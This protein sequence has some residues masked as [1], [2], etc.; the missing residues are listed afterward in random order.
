M[1]KRRT[2]FR[3][4]KRFFRLKN[5]QTQEIKHHFVVQSQKT[6]LFGDI[7]L[8]GKWKDYMIK[9]RGLP[10]EK[11]IKRPL[12]IGRASELEKCLSNLEKKIPKDRECY[13][14]NNFIRYD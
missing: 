1:V 11:T 4:V 7:K 14:G 10:G 3:A 2:E 9:E 6:Y 13:F 12:S 8:K 5:S